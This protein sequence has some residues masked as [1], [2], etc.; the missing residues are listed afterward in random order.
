VLLEPEP[1]AGRCG[2]LHVMPSVCWQLCALAKAESVL[3]AWVLA[4]YSF[5]H[6]RLSCIRAV[7]LRHSAVAGVRETAPLNSA[8]TGQGGAQLSRQSG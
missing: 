8:P 7:D 3:P 2:V 5:S 1:A 4:L 6:R